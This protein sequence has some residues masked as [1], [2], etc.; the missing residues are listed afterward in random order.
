MKDESGQEM[1]RSEAF[2]GAVLSAIKGTY[3]FLQKTKMEQR[4]QRKQDN[5]G[6]FQTMEELANGSSVAFEAADLISL[7]DGN[8]QEF[9]PQQIL[10]QHKPYSKKNFIDT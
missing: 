1:R 9:E 7:N 2:Y 6:T 10:I 4:T 8:P 3:R 5:I